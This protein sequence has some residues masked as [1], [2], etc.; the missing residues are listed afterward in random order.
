M[1]IIHS[2]SGRVENSNLS[3]TIFGIVYSAQFILGA[4]WVLHNSTIGTTLSLD[5]QL[6]RLLLFLMFEIIFVII[7]YRAVGYT[8]HFISVTNELSENSTLQPKPLIKELIRSK[9][10]PT[11]PSVVNVQV[12]DKI[13][14]DQLWVEVISGRYFGV[15]PAWMDE[16]AN[17]PANPLEW[18]YVEENQGETHCELCRS[19]SSKYWIVLFDGQ[20]STFNLSD[21]QPA[22]EECTEAILEDLIRYTDENMPKVDIV[23]RVI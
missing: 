11:P 1:G 19:D 22:C 16:L 23:S 15:L 14:D 6:V 13:S 5:N 10:H 9:I 2:W 12:F 7:L 3:A 21:K 20:G 17:D 4:I 18:S 8:D